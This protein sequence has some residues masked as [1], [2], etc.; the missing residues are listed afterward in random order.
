MIYKGEKMA[1]K[2]DINIREALKKQSAL[3]TF[4]EADKKKKKTKRN[5]IQVSIYLTPD[6]IKYLDKMCEKTFLARN[7]YM[8]KLLV[9]EMTAYKKNI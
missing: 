3:E 2:L 4:E 5:T 9:E 7:A 8:R 6:E 1:E